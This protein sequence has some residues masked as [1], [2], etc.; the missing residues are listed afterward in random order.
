MKALRE[1]WGRNLAETLEAQQH[2]QRWLAHQL[3]IHPSSVNRWIRG[4]A[5][6]RDPMKIAI[7]RVL[8]VPVR[9]LFPLNG[10]EAS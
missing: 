8:G 4:E 2:S 5:A 1:Q 3:D 10:F 6:P 7:A 9:V